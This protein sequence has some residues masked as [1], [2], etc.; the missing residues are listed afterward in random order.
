MTDPAHTALPTPALHETLDAANQAFHDMYAAARA[1][2]KHET[3]V[4]VLLLEELVLLRAGER[5]T[6]PTAPALFHVLKSIAH[7]PV[8]LFAVLCPNELPASPQAQGAQLE[9]LREL[10]TSTR[11]RFEAE[12]ERFGL[13]TQQLADADLALRASLELL[14]EAFAATPNAAR[15][16][17]FAT[18]LGPVLL[19]LTHVATRLQLETL[20][21]STE[22]ALQLLTD[23]ERAA[24][25]V[26]VTGD[27]QARNMSL[28]MQYFRLRL[29][30]A[31][32]AEERVAYAEG[33]SDEHGALELVGTR[34]LDH[35]IARAF[36]GDR[37]RLQR[38]V[39]GD[40][41]ATLLHAQ[42]FDPI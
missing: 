11:A 12:H 26:V 3:P 14:Q 41:A 9:R 16:E 4:L 38:D 27:H 18:E 36:F 37:K 30:E 2:L 7:V 31:D 29:R 42:T 22:R 13:G 17:R 32:G 1:Q 19:R 8:A 40:S 35:S 39:L 25:Q 5:S 23:A 24:L 6:F 21:T 28:G 34:R 10:A 20:H 15:V 33:V